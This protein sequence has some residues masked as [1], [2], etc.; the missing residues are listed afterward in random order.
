MFVIIE[1]RRELWGIDQDAFYLSLSI[2]LSMLDWNLQKLMYHIL[3][4]FKKTCEILTDY[5]DLKKKKKSLLN[6]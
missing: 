6:F 1:A 5:E 4:E 3:L 2:S